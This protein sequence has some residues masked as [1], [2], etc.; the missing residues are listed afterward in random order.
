MVSFRE[1][2]ENIDASLLSFEK[3]ETLQVNLGNMCNQYCEHCHIDASPEGNKVIS[4][5]SAL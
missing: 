5:I 2:I 4:R 3:L 1:Q